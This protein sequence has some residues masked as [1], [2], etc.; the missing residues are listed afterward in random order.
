MFK[1]TIFIRSVMFTSEFLD[2]SY[3]RTNMMFMR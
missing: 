3:F 1:I 2:C